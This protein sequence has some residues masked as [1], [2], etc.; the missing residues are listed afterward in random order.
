M[1]IYADNSES[2]PWHILASVSALLFIAIFPMP[3]EFYTIVRLFVC[4][5]MS[6]MA[7]S[8]FSND[9]YTFWPW[10]FGFIAVLFNPIIPIHMT[11]EIWMAIDFVVGS[12]FAYLAYEEYIQ[13]HIS[14][15]DVADQPF[16][17]TSIVAEQGDAEAQYDLGIMYANGQGAPKDYK[18]SAKWFCEAAEQGHVE[19]QAWLGRMYILGKGVTQDDKKAA[20][21]SRKAAER[22]HAGAQALLGEI[23]AS[24]PILPDY[25]EAYFWLSLAATEEIGHLPETTKIRNVLAGK[26]TT[27]QRV[28]G[29][30]TPAQR[31]K[32][33]KRASEWKPVTDDGK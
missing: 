3:Y 30:L 12:L 23:Y 7:Y 2:I 22:G 4:I 15:H 13:S 16:L 26:L 1:S 10:F 27:A 29:K 19:A 28:A 33:Q 6:Y 18:K 8:G 32:V 31:D 9:D 5:C 11:K 21:W 14:H 17:E 25:E 24:A 20:R